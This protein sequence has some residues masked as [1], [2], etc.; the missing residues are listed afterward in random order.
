MGIEVVG[1]ILKY[2]AILFFAAAQLLIGAGI[3]DAYGQ[4]RGN[5]HQKV[6]IGLQQLAPGCDRI[7]GED[8]QRF[9]LENDRHADQGM[10][11]ETLDQA[12]ASGGKRF[13]QSMDVVDDKRDL[14]VKTADEQPIGSGAVQVEIDEP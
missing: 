6:E 4:V 7:D 1:H 8:A 5:A 12:L 2:I 9:L 10:R 3:V 14:F 13:F 11:P